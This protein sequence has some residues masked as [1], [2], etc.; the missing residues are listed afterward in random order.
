MVGIKP[1]YRNWSPQLIILNTIAHAH[2]S[3][4]IFTHGGKVN[5]VAKIASAANM[6]S[7]PPPTLGTLA[8]PAMLAHLL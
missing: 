2:S 7:R 1:G 3:H 8:L 5:P 6:P 4:A